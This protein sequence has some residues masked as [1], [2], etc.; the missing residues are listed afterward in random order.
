MTWY[1]LPP[2]LVPGTAL[3]SPI[4]DGNGNEVESVRIDSWS[5]STIDEF[6]KVLTLL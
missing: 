4:Q 2:N 6:F 3:S 5:A 1:S